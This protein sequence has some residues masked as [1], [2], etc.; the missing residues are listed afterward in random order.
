R[1]EKLFEFSKRRTEALRLSPRRQYNLGTLHTSMP[2]HP[3]APVP[4]TIA[5]LRKLILSPRAG[6]TSAPT[7]PNKTDFSPTRAF[8]ARRSS[9][10]H[11]LLSPQKPDAQSGNGSQT[12]RF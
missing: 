12:A 9:Q 8:S 2:L 1:P 10:H 6:T 11:R 5:D 7:S 3:L 4:E